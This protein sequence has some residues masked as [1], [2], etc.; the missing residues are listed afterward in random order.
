[1]TSLSF[2]V[3]PSIPSPYM[4][5]FCPDLICMSTYIDYYIRRWSLYFLPPISWK[6]SIG[7]GI[8]MCRGVEER[9]HSHGRF[10]RK[11][12]EEEAGSGNE[13]SSLV[14]CELCGS[15]A[16]LYCQ[17]DNAFLCRKCD[18]WVH[19]AN[20]LAFR[21]IRCFLCNTCQNLTQRYLIGASMEIVLP[22][23]V[24][25]RERRRQQ[26][27]NSNNDEKQFSTSPKMPFL[28]L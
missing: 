12:E 4:L 17:A 6:I 26:C 15:Q 3:L 16:S 10:C 1:M 13:T 20:F 8:K 19:G 23:I 27:N 9:S 11:Q 18:K 24:S 7:K 5:K 14:C 21:H 28:F 22:T 25:L 2:S